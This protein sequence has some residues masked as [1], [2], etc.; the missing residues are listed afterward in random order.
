MATLEE[1]QNQKSLLMECEF[2]LNFVAQTL[3]NT[4]NTNLI[5]R[6]GKKHRYLPE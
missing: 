3:R 6:C 2:L 1:L 4:L 5:H